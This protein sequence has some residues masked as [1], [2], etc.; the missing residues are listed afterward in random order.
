MLFFLLAFFLAAFS[1]GTAFAFSLLA[2]FSVGAAFAFSLLAAF[3]FTLLAVAVAF[4]GRFLMARALFGTN[5]ILA[6]IGEAYA[7]GTGHLAVVHAVLFSLLHGGVCV[8][9]QSVSGSGI[10]IAR[11]HCES[12]SD[13]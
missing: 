1:V 9:S 6:V 3:A 10:A 2:A 12:E 4:A 11:Y 8:V 5:A 7:V 13:S